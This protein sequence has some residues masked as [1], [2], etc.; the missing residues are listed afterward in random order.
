ML[1]YVKLEN[2]MQGGGGNLRLLSSGAI[3]NALG[4]DRSLAVL[5]AVSHTCVR[6][7]GAAESHTA[8]GAS[9]AALH[10]AVTT[11]FLTETPQLQHARGSREAKHF[12]LLLRAAGGGGG[13]CCCLVRQKF[14]NPWAAARTGTVP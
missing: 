11:L 4:W 8:Q 7:S 2:T 10:G 9:E 5:C 13:C 14:S 3:G 1:F 6:C 12:P